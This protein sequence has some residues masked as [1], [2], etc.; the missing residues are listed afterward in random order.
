MK[1]NK[2]NRYFKVGVKKN[3][4]LKD[5]GS[6]FLKNNENITF[7]TSN[8][9]EY[10]VCKKNWGFYA[11]PSINKRLKNFGYLAALVKSKNF[12]TFTILLLEKGKR[13]QFNKYIKDQKMHVVCWLNNK[14]LRA[15]EKKF[16][17]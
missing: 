14:N 8:K 13:K 3:I 5:V 4:T 17:K 16:K 12:N 2:K 6:I 9:K 15:I 10:D 1:I 7:K 11:T